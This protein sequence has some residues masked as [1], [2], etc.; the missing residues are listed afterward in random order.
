MRF[1]SSQGVPW[2]QLITKIEWSDLVFINL[3][4]ADDWAYSVDR[5]MNASYAYAFIHIR[6][7]SL[8]LKTQCELYA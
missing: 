1:D 3:V 4:A 8:R 7:E 6:S 5:Q 2:I